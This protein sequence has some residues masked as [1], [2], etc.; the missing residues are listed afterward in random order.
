M[1]DDE[2]DAAGAALANAYAAEFEE[3]DN[4]YSTV[5][6]PKKKAKT[7]GKLK[8]EAG[9]Q[10]WCLVVK[11]KFKDYSKIIK[12][13][14]L[15]EPYAAWIRENEPTT[16]A[17]QLLTSDKDPLSVMI[18]ERY[19]DKDKAY[20]EIHR[21]SSEFQKFRPA[22]AALEPEID[23]HSYYEG[24]GFMSRADVA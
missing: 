7:Y 21:G 6:R 17:Y 12:L 20:A 16:L 10:C 18:M 24:S 13:K 9:T 2:A 3:E 1:S 15:F 8:E 5:D 19:A 4:D 14:D 22:L 11:L 23:G